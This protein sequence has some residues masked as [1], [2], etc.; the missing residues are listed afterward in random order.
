MEYQPCLFCFIIVIL[1]KVTVQFLLSLECHA[2]SQNVIPQNL[3]SLRHRNPLKPTYLDLSHSINSIV[4]S[5]KRL[6]QSE[7]TIQ[8]TVHNLSIC[9]TYMYSLMSRQYSH[10]AWL[11]Q[12]DPYIF[13]LLC[14]RLRLLIINTNITFQKK[15]IC[16]YVNWFRN[17]FINIC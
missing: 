1:S 8:N 2:H 6:G 4:P 17:R 7:T 13:Y 14:S 16:V 3:P 12:T 5:Q 11:R 10:S 9:K 15:C